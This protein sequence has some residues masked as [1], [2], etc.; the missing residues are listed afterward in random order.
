MALVVETGAVIAGAESYATVAEF[1]TY[2][3]NRG[4]STLTALAT[5]DKEI[6]LRIGTRW[7]DS[8]YKWRGTIVD[9][10]QVLDW[11][12]WGVEGSDGKYYDSDEIPTILKEALFEIAKQQNTADIFTTTT[13]RKVIREKLDVLEQEF[14]PHGDTVLRYPWIDS[15]LKPITLGGASVAYFRRA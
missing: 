1:D 11:P 2:W 9:N 15:L 4:D 14:T 10:D 13:S 8:R 3:T 7:L 12:R 6:L 5:A